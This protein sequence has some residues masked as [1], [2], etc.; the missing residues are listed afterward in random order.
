MSFSIRNVVPWERGE[1]II[2]LFTELK[3]FFHCFLFAII[4]TLDYLVV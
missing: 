2:Y 3:G 4:F 1:F